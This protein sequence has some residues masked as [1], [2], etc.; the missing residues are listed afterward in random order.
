MI[1]RRYPIVGIEAPLGGF[2]A[3]HLRCDFCR[4]VGNIER[5]DRPDA[6]S[7]GDKPLPGDID[8]AAERRYQAQ[9]GDDDAFH[10]ALPSVDC[11]SHCDA[12]RP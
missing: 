5:L 1:F 2:A 8:T 6:G 12:A 4:Q 11:H 3:R 7:S 9:T 10:A